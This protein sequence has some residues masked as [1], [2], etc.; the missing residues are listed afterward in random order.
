[1]RIKY[2]PQYAIALAILVVGLAFAGVAV[3]SLLVA[4]LVLACP[5]MMLFMMRGMHGGSQD[6]H[7]DRSGEAHKRE[8]HPGPAGRS[9]LGVDGMSR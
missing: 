7:E 9:R 4:L 2:L 5:L 8:H 6:D 3:E 1:M